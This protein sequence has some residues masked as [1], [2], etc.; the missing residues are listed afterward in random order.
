MNDVRETQGQQ[1]PPFQAR[2]PGGKLNHSNTQRRLG[3]RTDIVCLCSV[4]VVA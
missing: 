2:S 3:S 4:W 1:G